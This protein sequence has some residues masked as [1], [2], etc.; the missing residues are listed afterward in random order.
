MKI[1]EVVVEARQEANF[2]SLD[3]DQ[4]AKLRSAKASPAL[5]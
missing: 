1:K 5:V 3:P 4:Q 2:S